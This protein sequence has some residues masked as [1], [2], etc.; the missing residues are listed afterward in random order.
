VFV[1]GLGKAGSVRTRERVAELLED[2]LSVMHIARLLGLTKST[3]CYHKRRLGHPIDPKF[4]RRYDWSEVQ[5]FYDAGHSITEC[6]ERFGFARKSFYDAVKRGDVATRSQA[7]PLETYLVRGRAVGRDHLKGRLL[8]ARLKTDRCE[9]CGIS[10]WRGARLSMALHHI[11]GDGKDNRLENLMLLC[12]NCHAQT[13]NFSG[14]NRRLRR[15]EVILR[16]AGA[17]RFDPAEARELPV[18]GET[19]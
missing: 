15:I 17:R 3:V 1:A 8:R 9:S 12:P 16:L 18:L 5:R 13:P 11:N 19:A 6:Q 4:N 2:G 7:A 14:R 10:E